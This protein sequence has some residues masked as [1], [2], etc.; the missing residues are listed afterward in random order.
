LYSFFPNTKNI[1]FR[2]L[3]QSNH[4]LWTVEYC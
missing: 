3:I 4:P 2:M 1:I